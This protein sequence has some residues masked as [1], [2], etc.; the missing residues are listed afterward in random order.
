[1]TSI[2]VIH[3]ACLCMLYGCIIMILA[4]KEFLLAEISNNTISIP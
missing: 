3:F 1:M 4:L 2:T